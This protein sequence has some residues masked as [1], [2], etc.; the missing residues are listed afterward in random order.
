MAQRS[1]KI[2][3][4]LFLYSCPFF[5]NGQKVFQQAK[6][7]QQFIGR[8]NYEQARWDYGYAPQF[9]KNSIPQFRFSQYTLAVPQKSTN[10]WQRSELMYSISPK[11]YT[12]SLGYFC[13]QELKFE[14]FTSIP[15][16]LRLGS[17]D[18]TNYLEQKP[19]AINPEQ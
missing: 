11:F 18:Y 15:L 13:R 3:V 12:Q 10:K 16:R 7:I 4:V 8:K 6:T 14:K 19:N 2:I 17:L 9:V 1:L 5:L